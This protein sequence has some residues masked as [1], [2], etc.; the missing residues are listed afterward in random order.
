MKALVFGGSGKIGSA[1]AWDLAKDDEIEA[2]G[3]VGRHIESLERTR[4]WIGSDKIIPHVL[5]INNKTE[6]IRLMR[7]YDVGAIT[8]PDRKTSYKVV[9]CA[10]EAGLNIV[11]TIEEFHRTPDPYET[12]GLEVPKG[13]TL[14]EYGE[15]LH[16]KAVENGV[17][18][19][20]GMGFAPGLSNITVGEGIRKMDVAER[21]I[22][23]VGGIPSK[24]AA[25]KHPLRY[26]ITWAFEHVLREY[27]IKLN[28]IK[29]G[30]IVEVDAGTDLEKFRFN[31]FGKDEELECAITPGM[32]SF[33]F[34]R[35]QLKEFAEKTIRW[36]GH[37]EGV[38]TLK[39]CG[40]LD[41][42]PVDFEG[43][44]ISPRKFFLS[45][46]TPRLLPNEGETDVC[47]MYNTVEGK[48]DGKKVKVEYFMWDEADTKNGISSMMRVTGF[49][50]AIATK[51]ILSG[52]IKEKGIVAPEDCIKGELY[53]AFLTELEK[54]NIKIL[55]EV[56]YEK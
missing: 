26:M 15:W 38:Q 17:T 19:V 31:K 6:M 36:P 21:A 13:M 34:T 44:K 9:H 32:P 46:I 8:L 43:V 35:P 41:L 12:E 53:K 2:I 42:E 56:S 4:R 28:V 20:D 14:K 30:K 33:L 11:D 54:R 27:M 39:E 18:F 52:K 49:P 48:K 55:E 1:V 5:D 37:W 22:A 3:I 51:M 23:R 29:D 24:E 45:I 40:L 16:E 47:V 7:Q 25:R 10:I 50:L